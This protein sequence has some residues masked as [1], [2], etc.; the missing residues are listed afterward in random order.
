[1]IDFHIPGGNYHH[2]FNASVL[3][4]VLTT[5]ASFYFCN[6][7]HESKRAIMKKTF[8]EQNIKESK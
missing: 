1:M 3:I 5:G 2:A 7:D 8:D 4:T 6:K